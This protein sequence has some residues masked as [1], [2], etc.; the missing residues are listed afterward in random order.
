[1][2]QKSR[3]LADTTRILTRWLSLIMTTM[4]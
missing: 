3:K 1:M 4:R 2:N